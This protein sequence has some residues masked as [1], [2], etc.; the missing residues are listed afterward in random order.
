[1]SAVSCEFKPG[2]LPV[3][4]RFGSPAIREVLNE[5]EAAAGFLEGAPW[6]H[7]G[8]RWIVVE[9]VDANGVVVAGHFETDARAFAAADTPSGRR[10]SGGSV[11]AS[12]PGMHYCVGH[13]FRDEYPGHT[14]LIVE[15]ALLYE[16]MGEG[17][18]DGGSRGAGVE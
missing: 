16:A 11:G 18:S 8:Q 15:P 7:A 2:D 1:M 4:E 13:K 9:D 10:I 17:A 5:M 6:D 3:G 12:S 14:E